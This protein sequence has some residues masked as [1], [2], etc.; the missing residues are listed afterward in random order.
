MPKNANTPTREIRD[1]HQKYVQERMKRSPRFR[2]SYARYG[3]QVDLAL[4]VCKMREAAGLSQAQLAAR[5]GTTQ[6]VIARLEDAEYTAHSLKTI[7]KIAAACGVEL[8]LSA[9]K[10]PKLK[11]EIPLVA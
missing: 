4:L 10:A 3:R 5:A 11:L 8:S 2:R 7:E 1:E 6:S 9:R